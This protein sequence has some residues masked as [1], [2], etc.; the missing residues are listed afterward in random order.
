MSNS[1]LE[2]I[3]DVI[4]G[5]AAV[6]SVVILI[7]VIIAVWAAGIYVLKS[8]GLYRMAKKLNHDKAWLAWIPYAKIWLMFDLPRTEY[9]VLAINKVIDNRTNAFWIYIAIQYGTN[10]AISILSIIPLVGT[11][12]S[13]FSVLV[14]IALVVAYIFMM[15]PAYKDL[16]DM[17]LPESSAKGYAV[18]SIICNYVMGIVTPILMLI[19]SGKDPIEVET[20]AYYYEDP[21]NTMY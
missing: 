4:F 14:K 13:C 7:L 6:M 21:Y 2:D 1:D 10:I 18:T 5:S 9:R 11:F 20:D 19:A 15:Y 16:Y 3:L 12:I 8:I 17:F